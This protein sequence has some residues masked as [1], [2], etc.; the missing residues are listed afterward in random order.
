MMKQGSIVWNRG[1]IKKN[2]KQ[3]NR[4]IKYINSMDY[5]TAIKIIAIVTKTEY[6]T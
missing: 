5:Y 2:E 1:Q 6:M 3:K 4:E